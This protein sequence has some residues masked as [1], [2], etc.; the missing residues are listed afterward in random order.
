MGARGA[1]LKTELYGLVGSNPAIFDFLQNGSLDGIWFWDVTSPAEEWMSPRFKEVFG[2]TDA[3]VTN[4]AAWWQ[5]NIHPDDLPTALAHFKKHLADPGHPYDQV[6]RY[7]HKNG[8]TVWVRCRGLAIRDESGKPLRMLGAHTDVTE[9]MLA[10]KRLEESELRWRE[11][12]EH[13]PAGAALVGLNGRCLDVSHALGR[14]LGLGRDEMLGAELVSFVHPDDQDAARAL[15]H[16]LVNSGGEPLVRQLRYLHKQGEVCWIEH[17]LTVVRDRDGPPRHFVYHFEDVG[18]RRRVELLKDEF[19][20]TVSHELRSPLASLGHSLGLIASGGAGKISP[21]TLK[22]LNIAQ[23][24]TE[25]LIRLV[26]DTLDVQ[27][28]GAGQLELRLEAFDP[29]DLVAKALAQL[30]G[31]AS[32]SSVTLSATTAL[33][34]DPDALITGDRDRLLQVLTN[35]LSNAIHFSPSGGSVVVHFDHNDPGY[36]RFSVTDQGSGVPPSMT[37]EIFNRFRQGENAIAGRTSGTGLGLTI[38]KGIV[39]QHGG[40]IRVHSVLGK[41]STFS[42]WI[43][44]RP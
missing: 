26:N 42:F 41:G 31:L 27:K 7:S 21:E 13:A 33:G 29:R 1:Y 10:R 24:S 23:D 5:E 35:L 6:V 14:L 11:L 38:A 2:Y 4:S 37:E 32:A 15:L 18:E 22:I 43:P 12:F 34:P 17:A 30:E 8:S 9:L 25:R 3:E 44:T 20:T 36:A 40:Q 16:D 19:I 39:E 28:M